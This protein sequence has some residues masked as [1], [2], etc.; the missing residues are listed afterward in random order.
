MVSGVFGQ[1]RSYDYIIA[2]GGTAGC[3]L[4]NR[5][6]DDPGCSV[7]MIEAGPWNSNPVYRVPIMGMQLYKYGYNNWN[8]LTEPEPELNNR[9]I[10]WPRGRVVGGS[11]S[12]NGMVHI[13]GAA[14][15]YD[16][17]AQ[18]GLTDW[19]YEKLLPYFK[20]LE[21]HEDGASESRGGS[22][23]IRVRRMRT[24]HPL[25]DAFVAAA[26]Q[27]GLPSNPDFNSGQLDGVGHYEVNIAEGE[28][29]G[30]ARGYLEPVRDRKNLQI[31]T[32]A[33]IHRVTLD[34][35]RAAGVEVQV[36]GAS[37]RIA[38]RREVI[39]A[40]GAIGSPAVLLHSGIGPA[41]EIASAGI[42]P[43]HDLAGVGRNLQD[44]LNFAVFYESLVPDL[45]FD[46]TRADRAIGL[47]LNA[48]LRRKG[49]GTIV[50]HNGGAFMRS[51]PRLETPD[52]QIHFLAAG[53]QARGARLPFQRSGN[54]YGFGVN[55]CQ[56]RP[57]SRGAITL[58]SADPKAPPRIR[59]NYLSAEADKVAMRAGFRWAEKIAAQPAFDE[60]RGKRANPV[61]DLT[62]DDEIDAW[63]AANASTVFHPVGTCRMGADEKSV[64]DERLRV[65]GIAG[66]RVADAS[67]MPLLISANTHVPTVMI[68]E[69]GA[70]F[71]IEDAKTCSR[72]EVIGGDRK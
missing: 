13:R 51:D 27:A 14:S 21:S 36:N 22:G 70:D 45:F 11:S 66:L 35:N 55:M 43:Q 50:P 40:S 31:L 37:T 5:L 30:T 19:S 63:I 7:L 29:W 1:G 6:S 57:E 4:A 23:P 61:A 41:S 2:G 8:F 67:I 3:V 72:P 26:Q 56:L 44:H 47:F 9:R 25:F 38:A 16:N 64:V 65:R 48:L 52:L 49:K 24:R 39:L 62:S 68:A 34:G 32:K 18:L 46:D 71:I 53:L 33:L 20:R 28:R 17:W 15:D 10:V 60:V 59:A 69:R 42:T 54:P 58:A 12:I